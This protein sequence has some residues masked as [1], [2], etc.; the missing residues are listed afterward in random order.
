[1]SEGIKGVSNIND[2]FSA[3]IDD[4][5]DLPSF[6]VPCPGSY[7]FEVTLDIK[8]VN[9]KDVVEAS[10]EVKELVEPANMGDTAVPGTKFSTIFMIDNEYGIGNLKK[11]LQ[12]FAAHFGNGNIGELIQEV[13]QSL[14]AATLKHRK[15]KTDPDRV[16][17]VVSNISIV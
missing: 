3:S 8:K 2:L 5:A 13:K 9:D 7:I 6:E 10:Y 4:I 12:P 1:M 15:D 14:I 17:A 11:F 16:Y